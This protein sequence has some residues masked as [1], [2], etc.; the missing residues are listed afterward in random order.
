MND[1]YIG[2]NK[3]IPKGEDTV[4]SERIIWSTKQINDLV[5]ALDQGYRPKI[6]MPF[7][8]GKQF[9]KKG[10]IVFEYTDEEIKE[11]ARCASDIN[12]FAEK[13]AVVMTDNGIQQVKLRDYQKDMLRN[14]Q[15]ERFNIV[16]ASRQMGKCFFYNTRIDIRDPQGITKTITIGELYYDILKKRRPLKLTEWLKW[17][18][19]TLY[20]RLDRS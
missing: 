19:W 16:L 1:S 12:Y 10:N 11:L 13:Y 3:W 17:K 18:L 9:L 7:Y 8:E 20:S 15:N 4:D 5:L 14:F 2:D 6:K